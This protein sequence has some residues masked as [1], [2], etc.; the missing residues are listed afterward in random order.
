SSPWVTREVEFWCDHKTPDTLLILQTDGEIA[1]NAEAGDF[2]W[3]HTTALP[4]RLAGVFP[5]EPRW[6]DARWARTSRQ[7][8][9]RDPRFRD[10]VAELAAPLRGV[11]KDELIGEDIRQARRLAWWRNAAVALLAVL[12]VWA[13][14]AAV[15]AVRQRDLAVD[16]LAA[17]Q[18]NESRALATLAENEL[19]R[20]GPATAVRIALAALPRR[21]GERPYVAQAEAALLHG[22]ER[23]RERRRF[24]HPQSPVQCFG[25]SPDGRMLATGLQDGTIEVWDV[26]SG[27]VLR[28][29][30]RADASE[31]TTVSDG[32]RTVVREDRLDSVRLVAFR[33]DGRTLLTADTQATARRWDAGSGT[34]LASLPA[35]EQLK[36][37]FLGASAAASPDG[38]F[39]VFTG[40]E[41]PDPDI[42][43]LW[44]ADSGT[45]V[46][47]RHELEPAERRSG[48]MSQ[49]AFAAFS[50]DSR[51]LVTSSTD[52]SIRVWNT[53][54][55]RQLA[56]LRGHTAALT[57]A[58]FSADERTVV[59]AAGDRT[60]RL[61]ELPSGKPMKVFLG[62]QGGITGAAID[63][64]SRVLVTGSEDRT[65]RLWDLTTGAEL[66]V[67]RGHGDTVSSVAFSPDGQRILTTSL[68][69][70]AR[71][72]DANSATELL[73]L[74]ADSSIN[75]GIFTRDGRSV[76]TQGAG[77]VRMWDVTTA[78][79]SVIAL[80]GHEA[81][82]RS[83]AFSPD[84]QRMA[85]A[86]WDE[87]ARLWN[88]RSLKETAVLRHPVFN[89]ESVA[90]SPD[91]RLVLTMAGD[92]IA[93]VWD[94][95]GAVE[96]PVLTSTHPVAAAAFGAGGRTVVTVDGDGVVR[97]QDV[98]SGAEASTHPVEKQRQPN[99][100]F[101]AF[102][103]AFA[104]SADGRTVAVQWSNSMSGFWDLTTRRIISVMDQPSVYSARFSPDGRRLATLDGS[105]ADVAVWD[106]ASGH[107]LAI[108]RERG[109]RSAVF[110]PDGRSIVTMKQG[111][112]IR[113]WDADA[114]REL[115]VLGVH[116]SAEAAAFSPDGRSVV[117]A[118]FDI[119]IWPVMPRG[120]ALIDFGCAQ[121]PWPLS[122]VQRERFGVT[123]E[124]CT[125]EAANALRANVSA[126]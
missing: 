105:E 66:G 42:A 24:F 112:E 115:K 100:S 37:S 64:L 97:E 75:T 17:T 101:G 104:I 12:L 90:F 9:A 120:Q 87:T 57:F 48:I 124:W 2:D 16:R 47:L 27:N 86:A 77:V 10:L 51:M 82:M 69:R 68:D 67:L 73:V 81:A 15:I 41:R 103:R 122:Q 118:G 36:L 32:G 110:S 25:L 70:T 6:I 80:P 4:Q 53:A 102:S 99:G 50:A 13:I 11:P 33:P 93:R 94:T 21:E 38:R 83:V 43:P 39:V 44:D 96:V 58:A 98:L 84:G 29:L 1:W 62:H 63:P 54:S 117:T 92:A 23:L 56:V 79:E 31:K 14:A 40:A 71:L 78:P 60:A 116:D 91:G 22:I 106:T 109:V 30:R 108:I 89:V 3:S 59:T 65:A 126:R 8:R 123:S 35:M 85:I 72:W 45:T 55:A 46:I 26:A 18:R 88:V 49:I 125:L 114:G 28:T 20:D 5:H 121:V 7:A 52:W 119:R 111:G 19:D 34:E 95:Q 74:R 76:F 113:L 61:W 107:K